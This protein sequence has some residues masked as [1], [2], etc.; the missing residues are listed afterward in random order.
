M[1]NSVCIFHN[2]NQCIVDYYKEK[3]SSLEFCGNWG[4]NEY[5]DNSLYEIYYADASDEALEKLKDHNV[6]TIRHI[7]DYQDDVDFPMPEIEKV[8]NFDSWVNS[9][10]ISNLCYADK[11]VT[12][13]NYNTQKDNIHAV[14]TVGR[15]ANRHYRL[16]L[17]SQN[18][19]PKS[20]Q[21]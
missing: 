17:K 5:K 13:F 16:Y 14:I 7:S 18:Q 20:K 6:Y 10:I 15:T 12:D 11:I 9:V 1:N 19:N 3:F 2:G 8:T 21:K 4:C